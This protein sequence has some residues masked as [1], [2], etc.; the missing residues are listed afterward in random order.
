MKLPLCSLIKYELHE[1]F[2][3]HLFILGS[4]SLAVQAMEP[5]HGGTD[6]PQVPVTETFS[7]GSPDADPGRLWTSPRNY[8]HVTHT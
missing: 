8:S 6:L 4:P 7:G 1:I 3:F 2:L 5:V